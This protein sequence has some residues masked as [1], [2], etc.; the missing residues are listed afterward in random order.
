M[1]PAPAAA[2][3]SSHEN[4]RISS[5]LLDFLGYSAG[6]KN[7][8]TASSKTSTGHPI[9]VTLHRAPACP[10]PLLRLLPRSA[11]ATGRSVLAAQSHR[12]QRRHRRPP[13]PRQPLGQEFLPAQ[14]LLRLQSAPSGPEAGSPPAP[15]PDRLADDGF[16]VV[17]C[18]DDGEKQYVVAALGPRSE[19]TFTL[20]LYRS[21]PG[22]ETGSWTSRP[23]SVEEPLRETVCPVL[24][25]AQR[26]TYHVTTKVITIGGANGTVGWVD[27]WRGILLCDVLESSPKLRDL[28]LPWL[29]KGNWR[30]YLS[31]C[32]RFRRDITVSPHGDSIKY[33]EMEIFPPRIVATE[34]PST[35]EPWSKWFFMSKFPRSLVPGHWRATTWSMPI[36]ATSWDDWRT[37]C[38]ASSHEF[39]VDNPRHY[40]LLQKLMRSGGGSDEAKEETL[41]LRFLHMSYPALSLNEDDVV[42][43][44]C[45]AANRGKM[46]LVIAVDVRNK[47]LRGVAELDT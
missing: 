24:D 36:P 7:A 6:H 44:L 41:P 12:R 22:G 31:D 34:I 40:E 18:G 8:S 25:T 13:S 27:V 32:E 9:E 29:A 23:V 42:Y 4:A 21:K 46:G 26:L 33:V 45:K 47:E 11:A 35:P 1:A 10:L 16:A 37:E 17:G 38:T 43:L 5:V 19:F 15:Y 14:R 3:A 28:P 39:H 2:A 30:R 20:H